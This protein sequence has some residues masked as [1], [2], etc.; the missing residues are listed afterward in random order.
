MIFPTNPSRAVCVG[1]L[2]SAVLVTSA[3]GTG[4]QTDA[5]ASAGES[6]AADTTKADEAALAAVDVTDVERGKKP[7]VTF[8]KKP[9]SVSQTTIKVLEEGDGDVVPDNATVLVDYHGVNGRTG[10]TF[11]SSFERPT[12]ATFPLNG[13]IKGFKK[14]I[15][16]QKIGSKILVAV[17]PKDGYGERG[18]GDGSIGPKDTIVFAIIIH[19][20]AK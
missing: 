9:F 20:P 12:P 14:S 19:D 8:P 16:G 10:E 18:T 13:V 17:P 15:A 6:A 4:D 5:N 1:V 11:D 3:C 2:L 7:T